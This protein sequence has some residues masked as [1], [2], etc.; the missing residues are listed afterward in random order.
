MLKRNSN[1]KKSITSPGF[2]SLLEDFH[3]K[4][5]K[6]F[7][8]EGNQGDTEPTDDNRTAASKELPFV[9]EELPLFK[10]SKATKHRTSRAPVEDVPET[11][12]TIES[13]LE[14]LYDETYG[15]DREYLKSNQAEET[16]EEASELAE[17]ILKEAEQKAADI[18]ENAQK[19]AEQKAQQ[20]IKAAETKTT[21]MIEGAKNNVQQIHQTAK[22]SGYN[23]GITEGRQAAYEETI[24]QLSALAQTLAN[25]IGET[26]ATKEL[27]IEKMEEEILDLTLTIASKLATI[28][29]SINQNAIVEIVK[30]G[31]QLLKNKKDIV[32]KVSEDELQLL[33]TY[34]SELLDFADGIENVSIEKDTALTVGDCQIYADSTLVDNTFGQRLD[35]AATTIWQSYHEGKQHE[36]TTI[37]A[38]DSTINADATLR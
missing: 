21:Q 1:P 36:P 23:Q 26:A 8:G 27:I 10:S 24:E 33:K 35:N 6:P 32:I 31:L 37:Q 20:L 28:E 29:L 19:A 2:V 17:E 34:Q 9:P 25:L 3:D 30:E 11:G 4:P 7:K 38:E 13:L 16:L 12:K 15:E 14:E 5:P 18:V 22:E